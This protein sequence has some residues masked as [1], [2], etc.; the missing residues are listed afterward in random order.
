MSKIHFKKFFKFINEY[1]YFILVL[2]HYNEWWNH[3]DKLFNG[4]TKY[5]LYRMAKTVGVYINADDIKKSNSGSDLG[6]YI[7]NWR[8]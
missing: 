3:M 5:W 8:T 1:Y 2:I 7:E 4:N 6:G